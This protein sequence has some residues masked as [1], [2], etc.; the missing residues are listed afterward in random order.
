M[1]PWALLLG[2]L[3]YN[4]RRHLN[5][6]HTLCSTARRVLPWRVLI[7]GLVVGFVALIVHLVNGYNN[8]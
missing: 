1:N 4:Y 5:G 2:L 7:P 6:R 8:D 3:G